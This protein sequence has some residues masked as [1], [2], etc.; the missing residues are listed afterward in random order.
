MK[1]RMVAGSMAVSVLLATQASAGEK[2]IFDGDVPS[3]KLEHFFV[4]F[5]VPPGIAE[6]EV[7]HDDLSKA[8]ILD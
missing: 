8:N 1:L 2:K 6:I 5:E 4:P 3:D 7:R